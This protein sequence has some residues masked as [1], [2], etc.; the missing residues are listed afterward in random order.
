MNNVV[1][2]K[3]GY[4]PNDIEK[5]IFGKQ[6]SQDPFQ[7]S[8]DSAKKKIHNKLDKYDRKK[9]EPKK[10]KLYKDL[11]IDE[12]V[13]VLAERIQKNPS[14]ASFIYKRFKT[15]LTLIEKKHLQ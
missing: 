9:Y 10:K 4:S 1:S 5:K 8:Q 12:K 15:F 13:L 11:E 7:L 2:K 6:K 3:C 14:M